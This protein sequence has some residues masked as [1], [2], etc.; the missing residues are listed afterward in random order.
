MENDIELSRENLLFGP[1]IEINTNIY[2]EKSSNKLKHIELDKNIILQRI[3][4][5][6]DKIKLGSNI[7]D[8]CY[9]MSKL[10][11]WALDELVDYDKDD[12]DNKP[13]IMS[14]Y[15]SCQYIF[16]D[17]T[18]NAKYLTRMPN[19]ICVEILNIFNYHGEILTLWKSEYQDIFAKSVNGLTLKIDQLNIQ[20]IKFTLDFYNDNN[21]TSSII[22]DFW[23]KSFNQRYFVEPR[24]FFEKVPKI[25]TP[26]ELSIACNFLTT[27][28][29]KYVDVFSFKRALLFGPFNNF[30]FIDNIISL[31]K[32]GKIIS[33]IPSNDSLK[34]HLSK[35]GDYL[36]RPSNT[37]ITCLVIS[38]VRNNKQNM[39]FTQSKINIIKHPYTCQTEGNVQTNNKIFKSLNDLIDNYSFLKT[40]KLFAFDI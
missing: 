35:V 26:K 7:C 40:P 6:M 16:K 37:D 34:Y 14:I 19:S 9:R 23:I 20:I 39:H 12:K 33:T 2:L 28:S 18:N 27:N 22:I 8:K 31:S 38:F 21:E 13:N 25:F 3:F 24:I 10:L 32:E 30:E 4:K 17:I 29:A 11:I 36:I 15:L 1:G 5:K